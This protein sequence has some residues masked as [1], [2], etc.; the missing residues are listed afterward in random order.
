MKTMETNMTISNEELIRRHS[1]LNTPFTIITTDEGSFIT[2]GRYR[3]TEAKSFEE[4]MED[5]DNKDWN[6][7]TSVISIIHETLN[8]NK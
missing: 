2:M 7:L 6:L 3:L 1:V 5:I 8:Q 4:C